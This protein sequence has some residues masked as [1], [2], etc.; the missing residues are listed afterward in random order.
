MYHLPE[1]D[2]SLASNSTPVLMAENLLLGSGCEGVPIGR[3]RGVWGVHARE[4]PG[5]RLLVCEPREAF[6]MRVCPSETHAVAVVPLG[7]GA[8]L[9][10][11]GRAIPD[12][13]AGFSL[14]G[15]TQIVHARA[16]TRFAVL[17]VALRIDE[18]HAA[19]TILPAAPGEHFGRSLDSL[20]ENDPEG[21]ERFA[22]SLSNSGAKM[23]SN[24]VENDQGKPP[25]RFSN[26]IRLVATLWDFMAEKLQDDLSLDQLQQTTGKSSRTLEY[27]FTEIVGRTPI[28]FLKAMRLQ[29]ARRFLLEGRFPSVKKAAAACGLW[30]FGRF[31]I[32]YRLQF[33]E[34]P[35]QTLKSSNPDEPQPAPA[36]A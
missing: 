25:R 29:Q 10:H 8:G 12:G 4:F 28:G 34:L 6:A 33:G 24:N 19:S 21:L 16:G 13:G 35:S 26:R 31:S 5:G 14:P 17:W 1:Q 23:L 27:A 2:S 30:H 18:T 36:G 3:C 7:N 15:E 20:A 22:E 9:V 32:D 11:Q